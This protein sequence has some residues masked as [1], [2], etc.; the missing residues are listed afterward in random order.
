MCVCD[1][2]N[3]GFPAPRTS[4]PEQT[5]LSQQSRVAAALLWAGL[6]R[7]LVLRAQT[8]DLC[9]DLS[10]GR[11]TGKS[12]RVRERIKTRQSETLCRLPQTEAAC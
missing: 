6:A 3:K 8:L 4:L 1:R 2:K 11:Q 12:Q 10:A 5:E 7:R 9:Q